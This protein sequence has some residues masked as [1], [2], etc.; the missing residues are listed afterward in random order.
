MQI[1]YDGLIWRSTKVAQSTAE[2]HFEKNWY[3]ISKIEGITTKHLLWCSNC[4]CEMTE[5]AKNYSVE[6]VEVPKETRTY[7]YLHCHSKQTFTCSLSGLILYIND[8]IVQMQRIN[9]WKWSSN[10]MFNQEQ[11]CVYVDMH[12]STHNCTNI[13]ILY[14]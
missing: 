9:K 4:G 13:H 10:S 1:K 5:D 3:N 12:T 11:L 6:L 7:I 14:I 2:H 8:W